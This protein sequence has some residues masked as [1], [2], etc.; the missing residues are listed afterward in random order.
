MLYRSARGLAV[1]ALVA[2][3]A[4]AGC[5]VVYLRAQSHRPSAPAGAAGTSA[6][7]TSNG[8]SLQAPVPQ[9][10]QPA[11]ATIPVRVSLPR[12]DITSGLQHLHLLKDGELQ[13][14]STWQQA[15]WYADGIR[16][17]DVGPA[18][19]AGHVDSV[20]GPA[21]FYRLKETRTG[22][23]IRVTEAS[24]HTLTFV[25]T[26]VHSYPKS[27]FPTAAVY[28][29]TALPELRLVTCTGDFD[30]IHRNYLDNLVVFAVVKS[31]S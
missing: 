12:L 1:A 28:G 14:P 8:P 10:P 19:I 11:G 17:G 22:D 2:V 23:A 7:S 15:G 21:I 6:T 20:N 5:V 26:E 30:Y 3:V 18:V 4:I 25:V 9:Q 13:S 16:P 31:G 29:P 24:G 27:H